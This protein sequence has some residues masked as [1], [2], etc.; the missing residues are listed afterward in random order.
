MIS[1]EDIAVMLE[2]VI[3]SLVVEKRPDGSVSCC[4]V[5]I[6]IKGKKYILTAAHCKAGNMPCFET[7]D[8]RHITGSLVYRP[9]KKN[10]I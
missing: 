5:C 7:S 4:G 3:P 1:E 10:S 9:P 6:N 8:H 2:S